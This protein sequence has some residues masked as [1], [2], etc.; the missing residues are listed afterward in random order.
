MPKKISRFKPGVPT[1]F[2]LLLAAMLWTLIGTLLMVR[3]LRWSIDVGALW[4]VGIGL[5]L[6]W[7]KSYFILDKVA[8]KGVTRI[9]QFSDGTCVGAVYSIKTWILVVCMM[10]SGY[11]LR[12]STIPRSV[13]IILYI[14]VGSGLIVSSRHAWLAWKKNDRKHINI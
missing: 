2:H 8:R 5:I 11:I 10:L 12:H 13:M 14:M 4:S 9:L 1:K 6:G 7:C 3:G